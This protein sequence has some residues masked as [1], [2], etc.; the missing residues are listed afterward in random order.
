VEESPLCCHVMYI[1]TAVVE[2]GRKAAAATV[3]QGTRRRSHAACRCSYLY[4]FCNGSMII[5]CY[6][7]KNKSVRGGRA[8]YDKCLV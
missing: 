3:R 5:S 2:E 7:A 4:R 6:V 1:A 8:R